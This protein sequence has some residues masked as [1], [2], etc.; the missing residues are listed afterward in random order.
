M[1]Y[2]HNDFSTGHLKYLNTNKSIDELRRYTLDIPVLSQIQPFASDEV[3]DTF[4][5]G[6]LLWKNTARFLTTRGLLTLI[7]VGSFMSIYTMNIYQSVKL[8]FST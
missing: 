1:A 8:H 7:S 4:Q 3:M 2:E 5:E 6:I